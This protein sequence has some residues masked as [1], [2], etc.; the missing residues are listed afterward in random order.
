M[1]V[2]TMMKDCYTPIRMAEMKNTGMPC[3]SEDGKQVEHSNITGG[4][5][6]WY[7]HSWKWFDSFLWS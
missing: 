1:L 5:A 6:K 3:G 2:E 4:N 7:N